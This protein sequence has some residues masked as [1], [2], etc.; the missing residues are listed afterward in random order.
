MVPKEQLKIVLSKD[1]SLVQ[2]PNDLNA[3]FLAVSLPSCQLSF[4]TK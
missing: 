2:G 1:E 3:Q 4:L